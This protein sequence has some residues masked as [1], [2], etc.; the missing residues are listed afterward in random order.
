MRGRTRAFDKRNALGFLRRDR[1]GG[2]RQ[3]SR[4]L[5]RGNDGAA[6]S[7]RSASPARRRCCGAASRCSESPSPT[8]SSTS[9]GPAPARRTHGSGAC[10]TVSSASAPDGAG[11]LGDDLHGRWLVP[12]RPGDALAVQLQRC[13]SHAG[14]V[15]LVGAIWFLVMAYFVARG[16]RITANAQWIMSSIEVAAA[17]RLRCA[18][19][20]ST[21]HQ[22]VSF[23]LE[24]ARLQSLQAHVQRHLSP[25]R[26]SPRSTTGA[27]MSRRTSARRPRTATRTPG[28]AGSSAC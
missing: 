26:C 14:W 13:Q 7:P 17:G 21:G 18:R 10:S 1:H 5:D 12:G 9:W 28:S 3:C 27:G 25:A 22:P 20:L 6:S 8:T 15:T 4:L 24:L 2:R 23:S 19:R 11:R 16:V